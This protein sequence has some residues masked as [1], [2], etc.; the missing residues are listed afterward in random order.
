MLVNSVMIFYKYLLGTE[1]HH[2]D[3]DR[4]ASKEAFSFN[5]YRFR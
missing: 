2:T 1:D 3:T 5:C 4:I